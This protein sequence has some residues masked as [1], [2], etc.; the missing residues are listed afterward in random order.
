MHTFGHV[1]AKEIKIKGDIK[2]N[3]ITVEPERDDE[4]TVKKALQGLNLL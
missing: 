2:V 1:V 4:K 3:A